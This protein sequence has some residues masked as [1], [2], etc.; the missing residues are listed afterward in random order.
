MK[1]KSV[2]MTIKQQEVV[3]VKLE[4]PKGLIR[5]HLMSLTIIFLKINQELIMKHTLK[6]HPKSEKDK[7]LYVT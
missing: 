6:D 2:N 4:D 3:T 1:T 5:T 7:T